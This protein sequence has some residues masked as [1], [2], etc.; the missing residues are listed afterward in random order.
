MTHIHTIKLWGTLLMVIVTTLGCHNQRAA[1]PAKVDIYAVTNLDN[2]KPHLCWP[3]KLDNYRAPPLNGEPTKVIDN[4]VCRQLS[5]TLGSSTDVP[6][7]SEDFLILGFY[8]SDHV[9]WLDS[10]ESVSITAQVV[11]RAGVSKRTIETFFDAYKDER[12]SYVRFELD[13]N[14]LGAEAA[15]DV[16]IVVKAKPM[17]GVKGTVTEIKRT[18]YTRIVKKV[19]GYGLPTF[20][21]TKHQRRMPFG[22][23]VPVGLFGTNLKSGDNGISFAAV[24]VAIAAG[25]KFYWGNMFLGLSGFAGWTLFEGEEKV[26]EGSDDDTEGDKAFTVAGATVGALLDLNGWLYL[27]YGYTFDFRAAN[28]QQAGHAL[29]VG[30]PI[31]LFTRK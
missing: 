30:A 8:E 10:F 16:E 13:A 20:R 11:N 2:V 21:S 17:P 6:V 31:D 3:G 18:Y 26:E 12:M 1:K 4:K 29:V 19:E 25:S 14:D 27:G 28:Y 9:V 15:D 5:T 7:K 24:P 23:W 22:A